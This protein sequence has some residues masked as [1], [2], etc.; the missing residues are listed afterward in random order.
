MGVSEVKLIISD[1]VATDYDNGVKTEISGLNTASHKTILGEVRAEI[2]VLSGGQ[3][4]IGEEDNLVASFKIENTGAETLRLK[5]L[6]VN[7]T[8]EGFSYSLGYSNLRIVNNENAKKVGSRISKPV[9]SANKLKLGSYKIEAGQEIIFDVYVDADEDVPVGNFQV[10]FSDLVA[11]GKSSKV[12]AAVSDNQTGKVTVS[13]DYST[14]PNN[15]AEFIWPISGK[16]TYGFHDPD[17]PFRHLFE[18]TGI[19]IKASQGTKVKVAAD[20]VVMSAV[21]AGYGYSYIT[22]RHSS[23]LRTIYGHMSRIDVAVGDIVKQGDFIGR[24]GGEI[25]APGSGPY[26]TGPHLHFEVRLNGI[27]VD[28]MDYLD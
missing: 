21:D 27:P 18:H 23:N 20:G 22:I 17:Y 5:Y 24:S 4:A 11:Q 19:D 28:P 26:T 7:T 8:S 3:V 14:P 1:L 9:S 12:E 13:V 2:S 15:G 16:V 6:T 25:G 10:Y